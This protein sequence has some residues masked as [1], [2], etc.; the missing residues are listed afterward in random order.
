MLQGNEDPRLLE[1]AGSNKQLYRWYGLKIVNEPGDT[2]TWS[3]DSM[4]LEL[5]MQFGPII[6]HGGV[7]DVYSFKLR[8]FLD[9]QRRLHLYYINKYSPQTEGFVSVN[10]PNIPLEGF[11]G[12]A[13]KVNVSDDF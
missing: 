13:S 4:V 3:R 1:A 8:R 7:Q 6:I 10:T 5:V 2:P 9:D 12:R 11:W